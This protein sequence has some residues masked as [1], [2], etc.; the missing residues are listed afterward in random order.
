MR[1]WPVKVLQP[2]IYDSPLHVCFLVE[3]KGGHKGLKT[4]AKLFWA[5]T[6][7][8]RGRLDWC[9]QTTLNL[10]TTL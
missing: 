8:G 9:G 5:K 1:H 3:W 7:G 10:N 6:C 4:G 2:S